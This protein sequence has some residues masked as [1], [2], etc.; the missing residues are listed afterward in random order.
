MTQNP[1]KKR[2]TQNKNILIHIDDSINN[3]TYED[4]KN[5]IES[6]PYEGSIYILTTNRYHPVVVKLKSYYRLQFINPK[7]MYDVFNFVQHVNMLYYLI[8]CYL[9]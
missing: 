9:H 7:I 8:L 5:I 3:V 1:Y 6:I 4:Y 2:Y